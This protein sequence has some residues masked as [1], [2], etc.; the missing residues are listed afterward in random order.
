MERELDGNITGY[1]YF[2]TGIREDGLNS[3]TIF[4]VIS[5]TGSITTRRTVHLGTF[6]LILQWTN[7]TDIDDLITFVMEDGQLSIDYKTIVALLSIYNRGNIKLEDFKTRYDDNPHIQELLEETSEKGYD[8][9]D[10]YV[11]SKLVL[12]ICNLTSHLNSMPL[13]NTIFTNANENDCISIFRGF[14]PMRYQLFFENLNHGKPIAHGDTI[15]TPT[16]LSTSININTALRFTNNNGIVWEIRVKKGTEG[17]EK[18]RYTFLGLGEEPFDITR[19]SAKEDEM[20]L[21][22]SSRL[23]CTKITNDITLNYKNVIMTH[24]GNIT[25]ET[26]IENIDYYVFDFVGYDPT[27]IDIKKLLKFLE[28][29]AGDTVHPEIKSDIGIKETYIDVN[30]FGG[31]KIPKDRY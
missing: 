9:Y 1:D 18:F 14:N 5:T 7:D 22:I 21:N 11:L 30:A 10:K 2:S 29:K 23:Q 4:P 26:I 3:I 15:I 12:N 20:L 24:T 16:F 13:C 31:G 6:Q 27:P 8:K 19:Q 25:Q 17:W 28:I